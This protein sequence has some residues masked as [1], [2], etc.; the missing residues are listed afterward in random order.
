MRAEAMTSKHQ[1]RRSFPTRCGSLLAAGVLGLPALM[2][3]ATGATIPEPATVFYGRI[4]GTGS[5]QPF[6]ITE[7]TI[8]WVIE[9][10]G[11]RPLRLT[12]PIRPVNDS[13]F[14]YRL[15]VPH[16]ALSL[17]LAS[18]GSAV[19][20]KAAVETHRHL[21]VKVNGQ[22]AILGGP[23]GDRFDAAQVRRAATYQLDLEVP[24]SPVDRDADGLPDWWQ[25][26]HRLTGGASGDADG[27]GVSNGDEY[28]LGTNPNRSNRQPTLRTT[29]LLAYADGTTGV[30]LDVVDSDTS[31]ESLVYGVVRPPA[32]GQLRLRNAGAS[33]APDRSLPAGAWFT[34]ADVTSGR[35]IYVHPGGAL[36]P[37][38]FDLAL[39][40]RTTGHAMVAATV[41]VRPFRPVT[42]GAPGQPPLPI[43]PAGVELVS[44][45]TTSTAEQRVQ[46][47]LLSRDAG[48]VVWDWSSSVNEVRFR[49]PS[50]G[51]AGEAY[52]GAY[53]AQFGR[54]RG[55]VLVGGRGDSALEG[56]MENDVLIAGANRNSLRGHG[57]S[58]RFVVGEVRGGEDR[59]EDF[60]MAEGDILDLSRALSGTSSLLS[61]YVRARADGGDLVLDLDADGQGGQFTDRRVRLAGV[62]PASIDLAAWLDEGRLITGGIGLPA[63]LSVVASRAVAGE[64]EAEPGEFLLTRTGPDSTELV[65][66]LA[67]GGSAANG[68]DYSSIDSQVTFRPGDRT[69]RIAIQPFADSQPEPTETVELTVI[70]GEG[71]TVG[72]ANRARVSILDW[73]STLSVVA[74]EPFATLQPLR[75]GLVR[76]LSSVPVDRPVEVL[77]TIGGSAEPGVQYQA[78]RRTLTLATGQSSATFEVSPLS[79][80]NLP[81]GAASVEIA[82]V[83]DAAYRVGASGSARVLLVDRLE[84]FAAWRTRNFPGDRDSLIAF[85]ARDPGGL[86]VPLIARYAF[87]LDPFQPDLARVP[88]PYLK[89]GY[90]TLDIPRRPAASDVVFVVEASSDLVHWEASPARVQEVRLMGPDADPA[91]LSYRTMTGVH[92]A[93]RQFMRVRIVHRP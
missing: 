53:Q 13:E 32:I 43:A 49:A 48:F 27:D 75:S 74:L 7:G 36:T 51:S 78:L 9:T 31:L 91:L 92:E 63:R 35:L 79:G 69:A 72:T 29:S 60:S 14:A 30:T 38:T 55:H 39:T 15:N 90:L 67:I 16:Q 34:Q 77:L 66:N 6:P 85:G 19:P 58:D 59:L 84:S 10:A 57:G 65:V 93:P 47:Y 82:I 71:Y 20:L 23:N 5:A 22:R 88:R 44:S 61:D 4:T 1:G 37:T 50:A 25:A 45:G 52:L 76:V 42:L 3:A 41:E 83:P 11:G 87:G 80:A 33:P 89:D 70:A 2:F 81:G 8:E 54:D 28:R 18:E 17:G 21:E 40:D 46:N 73:Q 86:G 12:A 26:Q 56:S 62:A 24:V 64:A 68:L